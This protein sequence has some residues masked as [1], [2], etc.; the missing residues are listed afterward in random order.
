MFFISLEGIDCS[1]KTTIGAMIK[2]EL[3]KLGYEVIFTREPGG[4]YI[5]EKIREILLDKNN[6]NMDSWT[7]FLLYLASRRQHL[8]E[9]IIPNLKKNK[10]VL[11]DR[12]M[13][14]SSAYQGVGRNIS[15]E[16][17]QYIQEIILESYKPDLTLF[18]DLNW[19]DAKLRMA[20]RKKNKKNRLDLEK[21]DFFLKVYKGYKKILK[22][23]P[24]RI[25][26]IDAKKSPN[27]VL[28]QCIKLITN[29]L[30]KI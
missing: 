18:F 17:I 3:I 7:E 19:N 12:F 13:D 20:E 25:K 23:E 14:S 5:S 9:K 29:K 24:S 8:I 26:R 4:V 16:K 28:K 21:N 1:G 10:I 2:N 27:E 15:L 11:T 22:L 30:R 6:N